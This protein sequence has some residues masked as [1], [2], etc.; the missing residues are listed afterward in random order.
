MAPVRLACYSGSLGSLPFSQDPH[1]H[2]KWTSMANM[3]YSYIIYLKLFMWIL[4]VKCIFSYLL[5]VV[6][7]D[8]PLF[9]VAHCKPYYNGNTH[10]FTF[11]QF[12]IFSSIFFLNERTI[13]CQENYIFVPNKRWRMCFAFSASPAVYLEGNQSKWG[14]QCKVIIA[15]SDFTFVPWRHHIW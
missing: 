11:L 3:L 15:I 6:C 14:G 4:T 5:I 1:R 13:I 8:I 7:L 12:L 2:S 10:S 9:W